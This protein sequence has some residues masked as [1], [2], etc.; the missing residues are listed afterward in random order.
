MSAC[1]HR[2]SKGRDGQQRQDGGLARDECELH[3]W[4]YKE[5][6][7][8]QELEE[9]LLRCIEM[10]HEA[11]EELKNLRNETTCRDPSA[12]Y[13]W[14]CTQWRQPDS[15]PAHCGSARRNIPAPWVS[16]SSSSSVQWPLHPHSRRV[17][18]NNLSG[19]FLKKRGRRAGEEHGGL[20]DALGQE[21]SVD[22]LRKHYVLKQPHLWATTEALPPLTSSKSSNHLKVRREE[23]I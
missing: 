5:D 18:R 4:Y 2:E 23:R 12:F 19:R 16:V 1:G 20:Q 15:R 14:D 8:L 7:K 10:L 3:D 11:Q 17:W 13:P 21:A 22:P 6:K 9:K